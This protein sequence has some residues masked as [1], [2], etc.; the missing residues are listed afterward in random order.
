MDYIE[1]YDQNKHRIHCLKQT[2]Q[3]KEIVSL[4]SFLDDVYQNIPFKQRMWHIENDNFEIQKCRICNNPVKWGTEGYTNTCSKICKLE[5]SKSDEWKQKLEET[6]LK[7]YG[8]NSYSKTQEFKEKLGKTSLEKYG[9]EHY[10]QTQQFKQKAKQTNLKRYG[11]ENS[12]G[13]P[14][15]IQKA[16]QTNL[17]RYG[18]E[19]YTQSEEVKQ[20]VKNINLEKYGV[21]NYY[22]SEEFKEKAKQT[23]LKKYG[24]E[25]YAKTDEFKQKS[26]RTCLEKYG[27]DSHSKTDG[28]VEKVKQ[29]SIEKY[30]VENYSK[31][32][33]FVE[34]VKQTNL[35]K[36]GTEWYSQIQ[37][38]KDKARQ[39]NLEKYGVDSYPKTEESILK[40]IQ[41]SKWFN[42]L[43]QGIGDAIYL[44]HLNN[45]NHLLECKL[46]G[47]EFEYSTKSGIYHR[48][49]KG[50]TLCPICNPVEKFYSHA[51]KDLLS[52]ISSIYPGPIQ[53]NSKSVIPPYELDIFLPE[54]SLAFEF[55]G[56]YYHSDLNKPDDYHKTK[57]ELC[58]SKGIRL[59]HI[60]E[61]DWNFRRPI[62]ESI[63]SNI[64]SPRQNTT[65]FARKCQV[66]EISYQ[67]AYEF[68]EQ[69]HIQGGI[70]ITTVCYGLY[71]ERKLVSCMMFK[72]SGQGF[73]LQRYGILLGHTI[74]G[75]AEKLFTYFLKEQNPQTITTYADISL[76]TGKVYEKLGFT[77]IRRN[78]PN[79]MFV[80]GDHRIPKQ[81]IRKL[82]QGYVRQNDPYPRIYNCGIDKWEWKL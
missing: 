30:G 82:K 64:I 40:Q 59:V 28:F 48:I 22:Q 13:T 70:T 32:D 61:D 54:L 4:T 62:T 27:Q 38:A 6:S 39:T 73:E 26:K 77:K 34:K 31:T 80:D 55:N 47:Q 57:T 19:N 10:F 76:F 21:E 52:F 43:Q 5:Y 75:G 78:K 63:I 50:H 58:E 37:E 15:S 74:V 72:K 46:C 20:R 51:E 45:T 42:L 2:I 79:Y 17:K 9:V 25:N 56:L 18:V 68:L 65:I 81:S 3:F 67:A 33:G 49:F 12:G 44:K 23:N 11:V 16:K 24:V 36:Y 14:K 60:F 8:T 1:W 53:E 69:N 71:Y 7:K 29:T 35:E 66:F 41:R